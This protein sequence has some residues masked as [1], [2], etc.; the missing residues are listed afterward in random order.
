VEI[1]TYSGS[2]RKFTR[3]GSESY[4]IIEVPIRQHV[5]SWRRLFIGKLHSYKTTL[6]GLGRIIRL[7]ELDR[8]NNN[9][10]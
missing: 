5:F 6:N 3:K 1:E 2:K 4:S 10:A 7:G 8:L 9:V